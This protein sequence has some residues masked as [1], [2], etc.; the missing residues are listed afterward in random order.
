VAFDRVKK[1]IA[2]RKKRSLRV[3]NKL[4]GTAKRPR[5]CVVKSNRHVQAQIID[6]EAGVTLVGLST[7]S[8]QFRDTPFAK[9]S[10]EAA[11][12]LGVHLARLAKEKNIESVKFDRGPFK[13]HGV[14]D[15]LARGVREGG[16]QF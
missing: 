11:H 6:D 8:K 2:G 16:V 9:K 15:A 5:L 1:K 7:L 12:E 4:Q 10:K 13:Y 3:R 14:L